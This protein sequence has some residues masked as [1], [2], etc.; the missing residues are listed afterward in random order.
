MSLGHVLL[1]PKSRRNPRVARPAQRL[2][3]QFGTFGVTVLYTDSASVVNMKENYC[4]ICFD[5]RRKTN[6]IW[7]YADDVGGLSMN[8]CAECAQYRY[9]THVVIA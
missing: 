4:E 9:P 8:A 2:G 5:A 6:E 1:F 7:C 3:L